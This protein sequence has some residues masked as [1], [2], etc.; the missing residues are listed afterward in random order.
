M[1]P[2]TRAVYLMSYNSRVSPAH[3]AMW[4]PSVTRP[5][6]GKVIHVTGDVATGFRHEFKRNY[7]PET[8]GRPHTFTLL[9]RVPAEHIVDVLGDGRF[10]LDTTPVDAIERQALAVKAP[11]N[12]SDGATEMENCQTWMVDFVAA[13]VAS[14]LFPVSA[15]ANLEKVPKN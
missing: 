13:L 15:L 7:V 8:T 4:I 9:A 12:V 1:E 6:L 11:G 14:G 10:S 5:S 3:W 2:H